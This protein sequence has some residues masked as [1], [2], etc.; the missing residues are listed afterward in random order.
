ML[1]MFRAILVHLQEQPFISCTSHLVYAGTIRVAVV[2]PDVWYRH[3]PLY[4][5]CHVQL[6]KFSPDDG[7]IHSETCRASNEKIKSNHKNFVHLFGL[8]T[9]CR[10][11]H[12]AYVS[13]GIINLEAR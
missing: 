7:L 1:Y 2:W 9:Y 5:K 13:H 11:M 12:G 6:I 8:Y 4:T 3:I 10:M